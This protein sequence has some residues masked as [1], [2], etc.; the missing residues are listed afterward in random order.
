MVHVNRRSAAVMVFAS[1]GVC[2]LLS[3]C[4]PSPTL[5]VMDAT[6]IEASPEAVVVA[7]RVRAT[8]TGEDG[9]P[10]REATYTVSVAGRSATVTRS[11]E[12]TLRARGEQDFI[13][14]ASIRVTQAERAAMAGAPFTV[15][16]KVSYVPPGRIPEVFFDWGLYRPSASM[17]G[18]GTVDLTGAPKPAPLPDGRTMP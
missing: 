14:P 15:T 13:V 10:L 4:A 8:N 11:P 18:G 2:A 7:V 12:S 6:M 5:Q 9:L 16:G 3:G 17:S 1:A